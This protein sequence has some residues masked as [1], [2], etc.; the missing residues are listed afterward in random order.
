MSFV[1]YSLLFFFSLV[2]LH[3]EVINLSEYERKVF[4]QNGED[5]VLNAIF[6]AIG[7]TNKYYVEFGTGNG[8]ECNTRYLKNYRNW[9]G[10]L[11]D[12]EYEDRKINLN[13]EFITAENI[14]YLFQ[15]YEVPKEFDLLSMESH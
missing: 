9:N 14:N 7:E 2:C 4:S 1:F 5:G 12:V 6:D 3:G 11:M 8:D 15:K 10:L 13:R